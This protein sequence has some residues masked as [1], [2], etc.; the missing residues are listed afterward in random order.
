[1]LYGSTIEAKPI[2]D[3]IFN[4]LKWGDI[5]CNCETCKNKEGCT[6]ETC[7]D[8]EL[9]KVEPNHVCECDCCKE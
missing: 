2:I 4:K 1:L 5:M 6:C 9:C 3:W 7:I 8:C